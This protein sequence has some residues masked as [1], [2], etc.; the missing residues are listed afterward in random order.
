[1]TAQRYI[2]RSASVLAALSGSTAAEK[3]IKEKSSIKRK[4]IRRL[5]WPTLSLKSMVPSF[6]DR[7][8]L[9][10]YHMNVRSAKRA[11]KLRRLL[12]RRVLRSRIAR[13]PRPSAIEAAL[14]LEGC[15]RPGRDFDPS[16]TWRRR[17]P[18]VWTMLQASLSIQILLIVS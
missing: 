14:S 4:P 18:L 10:G 13:L 15:F 17:C 11:E 1:M 9:V 5:I 12:A 3:D 7:A 16:A 6:V 8:D 2:W